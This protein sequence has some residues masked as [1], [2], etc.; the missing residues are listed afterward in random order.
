MPADSF[1]SLTVDG[2]LESLAAKSPTPGGGAAAGMVGA[3]A[4]ALAGMV[5]AYSIGKKNLAEHQP[6]L[7]D[8][9]QRLARA[10]RLMLDL[11]DED[12]AAYGAVNE[13]SRLPENDPKRA[14]LPAAQ[15]A[16]V[17]VPLAVLAACADVLRLMETLAPITNRHLRSDLGIAA[18]LCN[19]AARASVWNVRVNIV[20]LPS[21]DGPGGTLG[22][23]ERL[24]SDC[25][26]RAAR[27]EAA[28][29][30]A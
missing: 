24:L 16:S 26:A 13:L 25:A 4:C 17:Q 29:A 1:R 10:R 12:A 20:G 19:G 22:E 8:A 3:T 30:A 14:A 18:V 21:R 15:C 7:L 23:A 2:F 27:V 11:A 6:V 28:C 5:V 9:E